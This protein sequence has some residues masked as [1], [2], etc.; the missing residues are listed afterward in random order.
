MELVVLKVVLDTNVLRES[1]PTSTDMQVLSRLARENVV[2][3]YIPQ[4]VQREYLSQLYLDVSTEHQK[5]Q[6]SINSISKKIDKNHKNYK[7]ISVIEESAKLFKTDLEEPIYSNF[8]AWMDDNNIK[9]LAFRPRDINSVLDDYFNGEGV[10]KKI[11]HRDDFPDSMISKSLLSL[12]K[13]SEV[14]FLCK[15]GNFKDKLSNNDNI[16]ILGSIR[17]FLD[18]KNVTLLLKELEEKESKIEEI[19][20][21]LS[22]DVSHKKFSDFLKC[23]SNDISDIYITET[24]I[25]GKELLLPEN[26]FGEEINWLDTSEIS[27]VRFG[28]IRYIDDDR[29]SIDVSFVAPSVVSYCV[30]IGNIYS[31]DENEQNLIEID[32]MNRDGFCDATEE[33]NVHYR[34]EIDIYLDQELTAE[35]LAIHMEYFG[36]EN[37]K[38]A[39]EVEVKSA[40]VLEH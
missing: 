13:T 19:K 1:G 4:I 35:Q 26:A 29:Y 25:S 6:A 9:N 24:D 31:L 34:G 38:V 11:K 14:I 30:D 22:S 40:T 18:D 12:A 37:S 23:K 3:V 20:N 2:E 16:I 8:N 32:S 36:S 28:E 33:R 15:D 17:N 7:Y 39:G 5:I 27:K 21:V 10:F